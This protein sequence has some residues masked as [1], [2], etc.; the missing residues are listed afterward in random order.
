MAQEA[1]KYQEHRFEEPSG[2]IRGQVF[3]DIRSGSIG[4][5]KQFDDYWKWLLSQFTW[6]EKRG[7]LHNLRTELKR[8]LI[9]SRSGVPHDRITNLAFNFLSRIADNE[10]YHPAVRFNAVLV[11]G[12]LNTDEGRISSK[13][14][15]VPLAEALPKLM[16]LLDLNRPVNPVNDAERVAALVGIT[17]HVRYGSTNEQ[18]QDAMLDILTRERLEQ[19]SEEADQ[20]LR[21][22]AAN[23]LGLLGSPGSPSDPDKVVEVL[24]T[25]LSQEQASLAERCAMADALGGLDFGRVGGDLD[26]AQLAKQLGLLAADVAALAEN[27]PPEDPSDPLRKAQQKAA[28]TIAHLLDGIHVGLNGPRDEARGTSLVK[29][30]GGDPTVEKVRASVEQML[31][32]LVSRT[33]ND[34][35]LA[36]VSNS[37]KQLR[38]ELQGAA[39]PAE[40]RASTATADSGG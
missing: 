30:S 3:R 6:P 20:W 12:D 15:P 25:L 21:R 36:A 32:H 28:L 29:A 8:P 9:Q 10:Q 23:I 17:R 4:N 27:V 33:L 31:S 24:A 37:G 18:L 7:E 1:N 34:S 2:Q 26:Y 19:R 11:L 16:S 5:E 13:E 38:A 22:R 39:P 40:D 35:E 14:D